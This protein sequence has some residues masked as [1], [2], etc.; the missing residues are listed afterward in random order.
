MRFFRCDALDYPS[1]QWTAKSDNATRLKA[2]QL[3]VNVGVLEEH[4][5][6]VQ[7]RA[8][9]RESQRRKAIHDRTIHFQNAKNA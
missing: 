5:K 8:K 1:E 2:K 6:L 3:Q 4:E 9:L 7:E